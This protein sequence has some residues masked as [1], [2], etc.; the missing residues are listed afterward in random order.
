MKCPRCGHSDTKVLESRLSQEGHSVRRRR[1]CLGC[2]YRFTTYEKEEE[3]TFQVRRKDNRFEEFTRGKLI[4]SISTACRKR[5]IPIDTI[6]SLVS[7]VEFKLR[8]DGER[9]VS[10]S[11]I[12]DLVM[13]RLRQTDHVAYVRFASIYKDFKD[14][15][16]FVREL[17]ALSHPN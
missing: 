7:S 1:N 16:Q 8:E 9:V 10:S 12:G 13:E 3:L 11:K 4:K 15:E 2:H 17:E 6:E 5:K 14:P